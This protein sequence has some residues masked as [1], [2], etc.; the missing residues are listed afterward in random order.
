MEFF[1]LKYSSNFILNEKF[2]LQ[3]YGIK[4]F[5]KKF[6]V[7]F[8][9]FQ[10]RAGETYHHNPLPPPVARLSVKEGTRQIPEQFVSGSHPKKTQSEKW[11]KLLSDGENKTDP[12]HLFV[13][14]KK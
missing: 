11:L 9:D 10:K 1:T 13:L 12:I 5:P 6:K 8:F 14:L 7:P 2:D 3:I 4:P